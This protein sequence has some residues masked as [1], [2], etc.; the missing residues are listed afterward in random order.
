MKKLLLVL[1]I[2]ALLAGCDG[3]DEQLKERVKELE[4]ELEQVKRDKDDSHDSGENLFGFFGE[5]KEDASPTSQE[6]DQQPVVESATNQST[7]EILPLLDPEVADE[8]PPLPDAEQSRVL[9]LI[10]TGPIKLLYV[11]PELDGQTA[12]TFHNLEKGDEREISFLGE[13]FTG[14]TSTIENLQF[15][16]D[17]KRFGFKGTGQLNF[18]WPLKSE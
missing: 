7:Q 12:Q 9:K 13:S 14:T 5:E 3:G 10:A 8:T 17:G 4:D 6:T 1:C 15:E 11:K 16:F 2:G 18:H